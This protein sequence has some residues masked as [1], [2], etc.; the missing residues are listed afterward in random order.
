M[1]SKALFLSEIDTWKQNCLFILVSWLVVG[2]EANWVRPGSVLRGVFL[3]DLSPYLREFQ[4]TTRIIKERI[5][6]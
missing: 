6:K 3:R 2:I 5:K 1:I 4:K